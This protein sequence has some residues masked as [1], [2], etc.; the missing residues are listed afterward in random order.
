[1]PKMSPDDLRAL[2][3]AE[4]ADAMSAMSASKL[5]EERTAALDY[6]DNRLKSENPGIAGVLTG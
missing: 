5:S 2:L 1:M 6:P 4:R 3:A